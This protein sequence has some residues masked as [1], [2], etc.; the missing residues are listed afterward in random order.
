MLVMPI[1]FP[2]MPFIGQNFLL[3][4]GWLSCAD[5]EIDPPSSANKF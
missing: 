2:I 5:S 3:I 1:F 4:A